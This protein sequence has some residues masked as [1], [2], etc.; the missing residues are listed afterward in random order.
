MPLPT[1]QQSGLLSQPTQRLDFAAERENERTSQMMSQSLD[2]LSDFAFRAAAKNAQIQ[3]RQWAV[4]NEVKPEQIADALKKGTDLSTFVPSAGTFFGDEARK[5]TAYQL[6]ASLETSAR[7][8][9]A[10]ITDIR[11][12]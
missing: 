7:A 2:R 9:M 3:G 4:E 6:R 11:A 1:Y 12:V 5:I 8:Q 10:G